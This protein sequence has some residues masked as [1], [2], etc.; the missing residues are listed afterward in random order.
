MQDVDDKQLVRIEALIYSMTPDERKDPTLIAKSSR[1][2]QRVARGSGLKVSDVNRLIE[3]LDQQKQMVQQV[4]KN[5]TQQGMPN[6]QPRKQR[7]GKGKG[8]GRFRY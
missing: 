7:K 6:L 4:A 5:P 1:R 8:R 2:R 3:S